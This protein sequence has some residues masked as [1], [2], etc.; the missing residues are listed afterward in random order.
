M[1]PATERESRDLARFDT[2]D[3]R[4]THAGLDWAL[5]GMLYTMLA[6]MPL[7]FGTVNAWSE[8]IVV[9]LAAGIG[10]TFGMTL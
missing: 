1:T 9:V 8:Q 6:F 2:A 7:A 5:E 10:V 4:I 3:D